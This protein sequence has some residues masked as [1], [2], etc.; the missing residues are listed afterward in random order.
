MKTANPPIIYVYLGNKLPKYAYY[1]MKA[2]AERSGSDIILL[3][4]SIIEHTLDFRIRCVN[5]NDF[6]N[7]E[8]FL[9]FS[10]SSPM[11]QSFREG[12]WLK[13]TERF[14]VLQQF[15]KLEK[16]KTFYHA[17]LDVM[18]FALSELTSSLNRI[19]GD[20]FI[21]RDHS[22]RAI[23]SL[24][25]VKESSALNQLIDFISSNPGSKNEMELLAKYL[26]S[27]PLSTCALPVA[28]RD[29]FTNIKSPWRRLSI[30]D[31]GGIVDAAAIGQYL[32]GIDP[33][34]SHKPIYNMFINELW[35]GLPGNWEFRFNSNS[36]Q[37]RANKGD[38]QYWVNLYCLHVHS[39]IN[40]KLE[41]GRASAIVAKINNGERTL[42]S[43]NS[44][45]SYI[46][47]GKAFKINLKRLLR[48]TKNLVIRL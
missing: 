21:P 37:F 16:I 14:Y 46:Y 22:T 48:K 42:I 25:Y 27:Y 40:Q 43:L 1:S 45:N 39:K 2:A 10:S 17:E 36:F 34:N 29:E 23:A 19:K 30:Q 32:F 12:F 7:P 20:L 18:I 47:I 28:N 41:S 33:R 6:Y 5:I 3:T 38:N 9:N 11:D 26:D 31:C 44:L 4:N 24:I 8:Q 13:A 35:D 15:A